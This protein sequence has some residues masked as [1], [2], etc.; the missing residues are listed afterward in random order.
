MKKILAKITAIASLAIMLAGCSGDFGFFRDYSKEGDIG[1]S[2]TQ[3]NGETAEPGV[4]TAGEWNDLSN[5]DFWGNLLNN[6]EFQ[7]YESFW[8]MYTYNRVAVKV[9][10][11]TGE[12]AIGV[13]VLLSKGD[14][15]LW[16]AVT[17]NTGKAECWVSYFQKDSSI[18]GD[19]DS[20]SSFKISLNGKAQ[21]AA[22]IFSKRGESASINSYT[23]ASSA[24]PEA[25]ADIAFIVDATGS[26][27][28]EIEFLKEDLMSI[29]LRVKESTEISLRT[30]TVFYRDKGDS[31]ITKHSAFTED[32]SSTV[33]F[34]SN[35]KADGGG[36]YEEA[37][38]SALEASLQDLSWKENNRTR[39]AFLVF[40][41]PAHQNHE[42]VLASL[43]ASTIQYAQKGIKLI[44]VLASGGSKEAE[45]M[46]RL[47]AIATNGTYVF[48]TN[49]SGVGGDHI[50]ASVGEYEV[51][52]LN[53]LLVRI[54]LENLN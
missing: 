22:P 9:L 14:E 52:K 11:P 21:E 47:M 25:S 33:K 48:L 10:Y 34:I 19:P 30:G 17:D 46:G 44:P 20:W 28:D 4:L 40:D 1:I 51:E 7:D 24:A 37:V 16:Q 29:L 6:K 26:M 32:I 36:D 27:Q 53:D 31:Y 42:G 23:I 35:Q 43:Q 12:P 8:N 45:F 41:A 49:D 50:E 13:K 15:E 18:I 5:W 2:S 3:G 39:L 54:L 38:H